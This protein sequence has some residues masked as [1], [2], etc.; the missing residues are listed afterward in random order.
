MVTLLILLW[1][2]G[3][4]L[5]LAYDVLLTY[6]L[7]QRFTKL[8]WAISPLMVL[9]GPLPLLGMLLG[10]LIWFVYI[11]IERRFSK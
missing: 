7:K 5:S 9:G 2:S 1:V 10:T 8:D 6:H 11:K 3:G 4:L